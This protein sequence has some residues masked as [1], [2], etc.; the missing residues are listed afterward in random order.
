[1]SNK[2]IG[3]VTSVRCMRV[4]LLKNAFSIS[5]RVVT[6]VVFLAIL[7]FTEI[8]AGL[9]LPRS[10]AYAAQL[11]QPQQAT[12]TLQ[13]YLAQQASL[14]PNQKPFTTPLNDPSAPKADPDPSKRGLPLEKSLPSAEPAKMQPLMLGLDDTFITAQP[15]ANP[16]IP[17]STPTATPTTVSQPTSTPV[18][19]STPQSTTTPTSAPQTTPTATSTP[20]T[21]PTAQPTTSQTNASVNT[22]ASANTMASV[23][24]SF[25]PFVAPPTGKEPVTLKGSDN[26]LSVSIPRGAF[27]LSASQLQ[28]DT[29]ATATEKSNG[30]PEGPFTLS[31]TQKHGYY[32]NQATLLGAYQIQV[33][34][35]HGKPLKN[36][37]LKQPLILIYHYTI[38]EMNALKLDPDQL[39]LVFQDDLAQARAAKKSEQPYII[40][41]KNDASVLT[42]TASVSLIT[43][44]LAALEGAAA[45]QKPPTPKLASVSGNSGQLTYQYPI[46]VAAAPAGRTPTLTLNYSSAA[47]DER[48]SV[49]SPSGAAG[50]G[51][52][53]SMGAITAEEITD[54]ASAPALG[55]W[56]SLSN[57]F[58]VSDRILS[59]DG[60]ANYITQHLSPLKIHS[61]TGDSGRKCFEVWDASNNY[62][63]YGCHND[64][65]QY[66]T[67]STGRHDYRWDLDDIAYAHAPGAP[68][69]YLDVAYMQDIATKNGYTSVRDSVIRW[70]TYGV[71]NNRAG[72][73]TFSYR[74]PFNDGNWATAYGTNYNCS[75]SP[76]ASTTLRCDDPLDHPAYPYTPAP[77]VMSTFSLQSIT[78]Y[79]GDDSSASHKNTSYDFSYTDTPFGQSW[80]GLAEGEPQRYAAGSHLLTQIRPSMYQNG[81][82][83][84]QNATFFNYQL[85]RTSY[86]DSAHTVNGHAINIFTWWNFLT[87]YF[88]SALG[89]YASIYYADA[90]N[91]SYAPQRDQSIRSHLVSCSRLFQLASC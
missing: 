63:K 43:A 50:E 31:I 12:N 68:T 9:P 88:D 19:T 29:A 72:T 22:T 81:A 75:S 86:Y 82:Q 90:Y 5:Q 60:G 51:W 6:V 91:N 69:P 27:D 46:T 30:A 21:T 67:D 74:A 84:L 2:Q 61:I 36:V 53:L 4:F 71:D 58:G 7:L 73:I 15:I 32:I 26:R 85:R 28:D 23:Q 35:K 78:T 87:S 52:S 14:T 37:K 25:T 80:D 45:I 34:N 41:L 1:M 40:P 54:P 57:V 48:H 49:T 18:A 62:A 8:V 55:T 10:S 79:V 83:K 77:T 59:R 66:S 42:L 39:Y 20:S 76:P 64:A 65:L 13:Q 3:S 70:I 16:V 89:T 17:P 56:Y 44:S 47:T 11:G 33:L 24:T 38:A